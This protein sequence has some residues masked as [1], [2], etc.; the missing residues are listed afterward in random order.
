MS[1][2]NNKRMQA[3]MR[4]KESQTLPPVPQHEALIKFIFDCEF[5]FVSAESEKFLGI[6]HR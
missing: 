6:F 1:A 5:P 4:M 3:N 2:S